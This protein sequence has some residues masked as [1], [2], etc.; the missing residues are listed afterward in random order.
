MSTA[1]CPSRSFQSPHLSSGITEDADRWREQDQDIRKNM[2]RATSLNAHEF[3]Q[4]LFELFEEH[5]TDNWD[6][7]GAKPVTTAS[8]LSAINFWRMLPITIPRP[9]LA[10]D[11][12]GAIVFEWY[13]GARKILSIAVERDNR[14]TY[15][16][17]F[18]PSK[19]SGTEY[20]DQDLPETVFL[21]I[22]RVLS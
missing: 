6:G 2:S 8:F 4:D 14:V 9:E 7:Y 5:S 16:G 18:G 1:V 17:L 19:V 13:R 21:Q 20:Y 22:Q 15:A 12:D 11:P 10:V 3:E